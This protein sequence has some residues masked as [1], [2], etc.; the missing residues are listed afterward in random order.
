MS[1][2]VLCTI[3]IQNAFTALLPQLEQQAKAAIDVTFGVATAFKENIENGT[4]FD[5]AILTKAIAGELANTGKI[6]AA[7]VVDIARS[8]LGLAVRT[9]AAKPDISS[10]ESLKATLFEAESIASSGNGLA[11]FYFLDILA[12]LGIAD[13][14]KPKLKLDYSGG[15]AAQLTARGEAPLAVQLVSELLPVDG[16]ELVSS[17]PDAIQRY[18]ILSAGVNAST[19]QSA[20][21]TAL[22]KSLIA[23]VA[24]QVFE[25]RGLMRC[26]AA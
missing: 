15:Y 17:F 20:S 18:A 10:V 26:V 11:G 22:I 2:K 9:G 5:V 14:I 7:S 4:E 12:E 6:N 16:V 25:S 24:D 19:R 23:P 13:Q 8:G 1:L 3:G 21:A